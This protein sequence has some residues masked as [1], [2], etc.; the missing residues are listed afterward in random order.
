MNRVACFGDSLPEVSAMRSA[1]EWRADGWKPRFFTIWSGQIFSLLGSQLVQ[2]S[3][4]WWL[5]LQTGSGTV[6]AMATMAAVIPQVALG[7][8]V[9]T[10]VDRWDRR[11]TMILADSAIAAVSAALAVLFVLGIVEPWHIYLVMFARS[12][13][14]GFHWPAMRAST[15]LM[16]PEQHY[17]RVAGLNQ[18]LQGGVNI[19]SPLIGA[20][21][22]AVLPMQGILAIDVATAAVAVL[23]LLVLRIPQPLRAESGKVRSFYEDLAEGFRF[24]AS[25]RGLLATIGIAA[26]L[27][28]LLSPAISLLPLIVTQ[29]F[30][31][32]AI[33]LAGLEMGMGAGVVLGGLLLAIWGGFRRRMV[34]AM[35][36]VVLLGLATMLLGVTPA[37]LLPLAIGACV[38]AGIAQ[39][40][41]NGSIMAALQSSVPADL[42]G[43]VFTLVGS[44]AAGMM[45]LGLAIAGPL[46]DVVGPQAWFVAGGIAAVLLGLGALLLPSVVRLEERG[47]ELARA[48]QG[49][50]LPSGEGEG[51]VIAEEFE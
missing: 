51:P 5:T 4:V 24:V 48:R 7:P 37:T 44:V 25:W 50:P 29:H 9:G 11:R 2:F 28:F 27:N 33:H 13:G 34:T 31:G 3:L 40:I 6:L 22:V 12:V 23:P 43:R 16:V 32:G 21:L 19:V 1:V 15:T 30:H 49:A 38:A 36:G 10:L 14:G 8:F 18:S 20:L 35:V 39:P 46:S 17:G 41:A 26:F 47:E 45:P 42:Q